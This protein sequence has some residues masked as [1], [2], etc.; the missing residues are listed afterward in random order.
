M[1]HAL[2]NPLIPGFNPDPSCVRVADAWY[3]VTSSFE[4]MPGLPIYRSTDFITWDHIGHVVDRIDQ[5]GIADA[6]SGM[7]VWAPTIRHRN[8]LF[9]VIVAMGK[10]ARGCVLFTA[11]DPAGPWSNGIDIPSIDGID[12]DLAWDEDGNAYVT[13]SAYR[14]HGDEPGRHDGIEQVRVDLATGEALEQPRSL[15]SGT[16]LQFP[17]APHLYQRGARWYLL[18]AE[19]GTE[20]GHAASIA[21]GASIEGPFT[22]GPV[23]PIIR[24][25]GTSR[26]IQNTGHAD[27]VEG[28]DGTDL[29]VALGVR[30]LGTG[31][32]FSPL[33]RETFV[34]TVEWVDD[35]PVAAP[36][37]LTPRTDN[38]EEHFDLSDPA[39]LTD[40][41]WI[42]VGRMPTEVAGSESGALTMTGTGSTLD[43]ARPVF[44]GRRQRHID[45]ETSI[46]VRAGGGTGGIALRYNED[47]HVSASARSASD[48]ATNV[49]VTAVACSIRQSWTMSVPGDEVT[50]RLRTQR[51]HRL[52][53]NDGAGGDLIAIEATGIDGIPVIVA[54][55]D[56]R[57]WSTE[58]AASF[59]GRV[60]GPFAESGEVRFREYIYRGNDAVPPTSPIALIRELASQ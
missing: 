35:W 20:R 33:G 22:G 29:F 34:T 1:P 12:P 46:M 53:P 30:P 14:M 45:S 39:H 16:G 26:P 37:H 31:S 18:I 24:S 15:W 27:L 42:A 23:N 9:Y 51:P 21:R 47:F 41:G 52:M 25:S 19:G 55:L 10:S 38:V 17:E 13:Y 8:G 54:E 11:D 40:P 7:G 2:P 57:F 32:S 43:E 60:I 48:A 36:I 49:T 50:L 56:G 3:I 58:V 28:P 44:M 5:S 59:T 6:A 4:Y